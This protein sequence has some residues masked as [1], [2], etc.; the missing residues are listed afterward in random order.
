[1]NSSSSSITDKTKQKDIG[2]DRVA[3]KAI[4]EREYRASL[5]E[6]WGLVLQQLHPAKNVFYGAKVIRLCA[7][8]SLVKS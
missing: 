7:F 4:I 8:V 1:M 5:P 2:E 3:G 6:V